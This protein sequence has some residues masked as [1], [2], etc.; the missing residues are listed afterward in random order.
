MIW[1]WLGFQIY[2]DT[3]LEWPIRK[4]STVLETPLLL[5]QV[6]THLCKKHSVSFSNKNGFLIQ[7]GFPTHIYNERGHL[8]FPIFVSYV[9]FL[10]PFHAIPSLIKIT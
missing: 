7:N 10:S 2:I 5:V 1:N 8:Y 9:S 4:Y 3:K 6:V